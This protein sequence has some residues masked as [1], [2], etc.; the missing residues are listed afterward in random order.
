[1]SVSKVSHWSVT[2][3]RFLRRCEVDRA[4]VYALLSRVWQVAAGPITIILIA[5]Y[6]SPEVQGFYYTFASLLALQS[7][8]ELGFYVVIINVTSHEWS[9]LIIN[10]HGCLEGHPEALSRLIS[11]GRLICKW[12]AVVSIVFIICVSVAGYFFFSQSDYPGVHWR[13]PWFWIVACTGLLLWMLPFNSMLEGCNQ[14]AAINLF[15]F[16]Q[17]LLASLAFWLALAWHWGLWAAVAMVTARL[18][19]NAYLLG[20]S[21]RSFFKPFFTYSVSEKMSWKREI[22]PMQWRLALSGIVNYFALS[23]FNPVMFHYHGATVAG[24]MGMTWQIV[25]ALQAVG[26]AWVTTKVPRF[27]MLIAGKQY[28][29]LDR[30]WLRTSLVSISVVCLGAIALWFILF[31]LNA[32]KIEIAQRLLPLLPAG[33]FLMSCLLMLVLQCQCAYLRAHK[34]EPIV[35]MSVTTSI[36]IGLAV[37]LLGSRFGPLGAAWG[38]L[39][40]IS[41]SVIW[42]TRIWYRCRAQWHRNKE[43]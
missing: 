18:I 24:C 39:G 22:W 5:G 19:S 3:K 12:Y 4:V 10:S 9:R 17:T 20:V 23:L 29:E 14:V 27:G 26:S 28:K 37:W 43:V 32:F 41:L 13:A 38:Y 21:Y 11:L 40:V 42:E 30:L 8:V 6:F 36:M 35:V 15:R 1:M 2:L 33:I 7:F 25:G 16:V 31:G 34:K